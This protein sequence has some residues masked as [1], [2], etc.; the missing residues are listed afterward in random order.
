MLSIRAVTHAATVQISDPG[1]NTQAPSDPFSRWATGLILDPRDVPFVALITQASLIVL[2]FAIYLFLP[3]RFRWWLA[4][5]YLAVVFAGFLDRYI[6]ML[7]NTSHR[8]LFRPRLRWM[9]HYIPWV[10]GPFFGESPETYY[11]HHIG[12]HHPE[13]NLEDDLSSTMAFQ[14]DRIDHFLRYF[15]RFFFVGLAEC[16][17]YLHS[18]GRRTLMIRMVLG[19][20]TFLA[21]VALLLALNWR[22]ALTVFVIPFVAV[23]FLM[24]AGNWGQHAFIDA[25]KPDSA[26]GNSIT[27]IN[28]RY[29]RRAFN[30]GYHIGHHVRAN[31][32]W[33]EMPGDFLKNLPTYAS[34]GAIVFEGIDFFMV[35]LFLM[36][37]RYDWL[38]ARYVNLDGRVRSREEIVAL[39]RVRTQPVLTPASDLSPLPSP[40]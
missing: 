2:P 36:L 23:R 18:K 20:L 34:Q 13:N 33:T 22:A 21:S 15:F 35:W 16:S 14:R 24:M 27:C 28:S 3:G 5:I 31:R 6:L 17:R 37:R 12:M 32:H 8:T 4:A 10:L 38:A 25:A 26:Y 30:D 29:N 7:H 11:S 19:E 39:L 1:A 9:N 40:L